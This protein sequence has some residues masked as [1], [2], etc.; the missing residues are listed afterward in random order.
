MN[1]HAPKTRHGSSL[2]LIA[3]LLPLWACGPTI[4]RFSPMAYERATSLKVESLAVME[5]AS[6]PFERHA[7]AAGEIRASLDKAYEYARGRPGNAI[8]TRMWE[9]VRDPERNLLGG[10][11]ARWE[12]ES[13]L[14]P[15]FIE[16][17]QALVSDAFDSIIGLESG[18]LKPDEVEVP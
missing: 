18:K 9:V 8:S 5:R 14:S 3:A 4:S 10:F 12:R 7:E 17:A 13:R 16:E 1:G 11:L 2:V 15:A 6:E